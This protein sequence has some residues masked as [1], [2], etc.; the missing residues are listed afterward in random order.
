M[1]L[2]TLRLKLSTLFSTIVPACFK[3]WVSSLGELGFPHVHSPYYY[4]YYSIN[5]N[6]VYWETT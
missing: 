6:S 1:H 5:T 3:H 4:V 2:S